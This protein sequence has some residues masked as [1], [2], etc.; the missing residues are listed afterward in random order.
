M[1]NLRKFSGK[2]K[3]ENNYIQGYPQRM[4]YKDDL[5]L[6]QYDDSKIQFYLLP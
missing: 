5:K 3:K 6:F 2:R 1:E 4:D